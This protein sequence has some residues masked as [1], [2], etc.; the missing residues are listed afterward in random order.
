MK[1]IEIL[2]PYQFKRIFNNK[3]SIIKE[4]K[5]GNY[6]YGCVMACISKDVEIPNLIMDD[7]YYG[8]NNDKG[9]EAEKHITLL[10]GLNQ[11]VNEN[12]VISFLCNIKMSL[13]SLTGISTFSNKDYDVVKFDVESEEL[14][15][16]NK[17]LK[18]QFEFTSQ[19]DTYVPHMTISYMKPGTGDLYTNVFNE[20]QIYKID[21]WIYSMANMKKIAIYSDGSVITL[22]EA[23]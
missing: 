16:F 11:D 21:K 9:I 18:L 20:K 1:N 23:Q 5:D 22:R 19:F 10:Y 14:H 6:N 7:V 17:L 15:L 13:I 2:N 8:D 4:K 12:E 3:C